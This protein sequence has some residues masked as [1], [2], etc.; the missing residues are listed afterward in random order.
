MDV[1]RSGATSIAVAALILMILFGALVL[2][3]YA[4]GGGYDRPL[5]QRVEEAGR[6]SKAGLKVIVWKGL[7]GLSP[8]A[9]IVIHDLYGYGA[10]VDYVLATDSNGTVKYQSQPMTVSIKGCKAV[11]ASSLGLPRMFKALNESYPRIIVHS[12]D[13]VVVD[14]EYREPLPEE[15]YPCEVEPPEHAVYAL[16]V[17]VWLIDCDGQENACGG[18]NC[19]GMEKKCAKPLCKPG[20]PP[21]GGSGEVPV[22]PYSTV[23]LTAEPTINVHGKSYVFQGWLVEYTPPKWGSELFKDNPLQLFVDSHFHVKALYKQVCS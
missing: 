7:A 17:V 23:T 15:V 19:V 12:T 22:D 14:A 3:W 13:G 4:R 11:R 10:T 8:T 6:L 18:C 1:K 9:W 20:P 16:N 21:G 5:V 2:A